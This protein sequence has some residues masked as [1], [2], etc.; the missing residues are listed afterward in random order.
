MKEEHNTF[1]APMKENTEMFNI[2]DRKLNY[3]VIVALL[4]VLAMLVTVLQGILSHEK[5]ITMAK[6]GVITL[7]LTGAVTFYLGI[8][9]KEVMKKRLAGTIIVLGYLISIGLLL[10]VP[11]PGLM[12]FWMVGGLVIAMLLDNKIGLLFN[13]NLVFIMGIS[14]GI[15]LQLIIQILIICILLSIL[16]GALKE[17]STFVY[18]AIIILSVNITLACAI[19]NFV[20]EEITNYNYFYS[21]ISIFSVL[22]A[23]FIISLLYHRFI[24]GDVPE[25]VVEQITSMPEAAKPEVAK[26][27]TAVTVELPVVETENVEIRSLSSET[28]KNETLTDEINDSS[29]AKQ[30]SNRTS[31]EIL[32]DGNNLLLKKLKEFS[33]SLY[34][35]AERIGD[36]SAR[37]AKEIGADELLAKAGGLYHEIGKLNGKNYIEEGI[38]IAQEYAFPRE[39]TAILQ[40]HNI[41][42]DKP[43]SVEAAIVML[44]DNVVSTIEYIQKSEENKYTTNKIIENIFQMRLDKGTLDSAGISLKDYKILKEFYQKEFKP[45][46]K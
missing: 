10:F 12:N 36:L 3:P 26:Q 5:V 32:C 24:A 39:L 34:A 37:A 38:K 45:G 41:K 1:T 21:L 27:E 22:A 11:D 17:K 6:I 19:N 31:F 2:D 15:Q 8:Y 25:N 9:A 13:F 33:E 4:P 20:F 30:E 40:E 43:S 44:S 46:E 14:M 23:A 42:Y 35:H 7:I 18:A 16:S 28:N 29:I